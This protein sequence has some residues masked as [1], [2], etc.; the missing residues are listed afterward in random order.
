MDGVPIGL[1]I[2]GRPDDDARL[3][4][5]ARAFERSFRFTE[6]PADFEQ[7]AS[8]GR[9]SVY[10]EWSPSP[11]PSRAI[12]IAARRSAACSRIRYLW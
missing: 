6:R 12:A 1:Q 2:I 11:W 7:S 9:G 4:R 3:F 5:I 10:L 8:S